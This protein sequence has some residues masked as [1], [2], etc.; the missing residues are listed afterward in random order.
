[1][2]PV[3]EM[4]AYLETA[5][6]SIREEMVSDSCAS[7]DAGLP[8]RMFPFLVTGPESF[9]F[10]RQVLKVSIPCD[11]SGRFPLLVTDPGVSVPYV[12]P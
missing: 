3:L 1:M 10:L 2:I 9:R 11:R 6:Y 4:L 7:R 8:A 12:R 5:D